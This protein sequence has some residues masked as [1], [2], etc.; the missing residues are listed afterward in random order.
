MD[1]DDGKIYLNEINTMPGFT[2]ISMFPQ[3]MK[4]A[5]V[6]Y[7]DLVDKLIKLGVERFTDK[8]RNKVLFDSG[9]DWFN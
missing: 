6:D 5:G 1:R 7:G 4:A 2:S 3:F 9:S 8:Q